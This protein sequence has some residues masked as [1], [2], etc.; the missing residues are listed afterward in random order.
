MK[1]P[2]ALVMRAHARDYVGAV[3]QSVSITLITITFAASANVRIYNTAVFYEAVRYFWR[4]GFGVRGVLEPPELPPRHAPERLC[5]GR[6]KILQ[7]PVGN[8]LEEPFT[9]FQVLS[10]VFPTEDSRNESY[11]TLRQ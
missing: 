1:T 3:L 11:F 2:P 7:T 10:T 9:D 4:L 8:K 6:N 5:E